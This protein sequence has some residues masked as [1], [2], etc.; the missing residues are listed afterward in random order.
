MTD[1]AEMFVTHR[2]AQEVVDG[3]RLVCAAERQACQRHLQDLQRQGTEE[4]PYIFD[5]TRANRVFDWFEKCCCHVRGV[6]SGQHIQLMPFQ[7]FDLGNI[8]GWVH[9]TSG[10]RRFKRSFNFRARG[11]VKSTEMSGIALYGM[12]SD[13]IY[14]PYRPEKRM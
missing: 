12:C 4:F 8:F 9:M 7:Y 3:L 10:A 5:E 1:Y 2:Y 13:V 6:Y 14:P 11:N